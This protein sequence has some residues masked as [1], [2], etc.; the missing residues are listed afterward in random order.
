VGISTSRW[1]P[2][3]SPSN[4]S[5]PA[6]LAFEVKDNEKGQEQEHTPVVTVP[7]R[8]VNFSYDPNN[9]EKLL[10]TAEKFANVKAFLM[11]KA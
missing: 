7:R 8:A 5:Q 4:S 1:A 2:G 11:A 3:N 6:E 10:E 9:A